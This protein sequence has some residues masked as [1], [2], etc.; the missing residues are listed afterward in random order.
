MAL[1][2]VQYLPAT[3]DRIKAGAMASWAITVLRYPE[4]RNHRYTHL[5]MAGYES[6]AQ[7]EKQMPCRSRPLHS[8]R[9]PL[10][11]T[12]LSRWPGRRPSAP[13]VNHAGILVE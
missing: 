2:R 13:D 12:Q 8:D 10:V 9:A 5:S 3:E 4:D 7:M 1:Q 11:R 6:L